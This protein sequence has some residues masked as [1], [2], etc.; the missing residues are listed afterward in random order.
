LIVVAGSLAAIH[1]AEHHRVSG[2]APFAGGL[3]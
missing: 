3:L 1:R 2:S